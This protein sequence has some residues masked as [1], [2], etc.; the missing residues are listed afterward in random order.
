MQR[1][2]D[3]MTSRQKGCA[4]YLGVCVCLALAVVF[5]PQVFYFDQTRE[6]ETN[7]RHRALMEMEDQVNLL[8]ASSAAAC[9]GR[10]L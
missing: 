3:R 10:S 7:H 9:H 8:A 6:P 1:V 5:T 4:V 2:L